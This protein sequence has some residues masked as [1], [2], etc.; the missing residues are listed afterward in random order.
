MVTYRLYSD[1]EL[2][3]LLRRSDVAAFTEIYD[4]YWNT[5]MAIAYNHTKDKSAAQEI[6]QSLFI[7]IWNRRD[8]L[9]IRILKRY[10]ATAV[11]FSVFKQIERERRRRDIENKEYKLNGYAD[12]DQKIEA[13]F[14]Q[15]YINGQV[16]LLPEKCRLV[17]NYSRVIGMTIPQIAKKMNISEKT[18]E[19]HL[20][21]GLKT[22][23][24]NL[25]DSGI[26]T[27]VVS[28]TVHEILK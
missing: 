28:T 7:G 19:G 21:K 26:L 12:D 20:T 5:L 27:L 14:L 23:K 13:K 10:L 24:M 11:K 22:I 2:V 3:A 6:V 16:D 15:E 9:D 8:Q 25:K 18:V 17:F 1:Q 4:R